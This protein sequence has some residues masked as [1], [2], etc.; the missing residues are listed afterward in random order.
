M[1]QRSFTKNL[2]LLIT[3]AIFM[4]VGQSL[5]AYDIVTYALTSNLT[6]TSAEI[7]SVLNPKA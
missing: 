5:L 3:T 7:C 1:E 2:R 6:S 4:C